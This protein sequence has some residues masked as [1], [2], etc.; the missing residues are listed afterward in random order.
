MRCDIS[1]P[2]TGHGSGPGGSR[3][4]VAATTDVVNGDKDDVLGLLPWFPTVSHRISRRGGKGGDFS[5]ADLEIVCVV[6]ED[7]VEERVELDAIIVR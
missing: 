7:E 3:A 6:W 1:S 2:Q 4:V 5:D